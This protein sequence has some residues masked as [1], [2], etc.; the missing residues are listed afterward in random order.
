VCVDDEKAEVIAAGV[1][2]SFYLAGAE[3]VR[4]NLMEGIVVAVSAENSFFCAYIVTNPETTVVHKLVSS[5]PFQR[6]RCLY[7]VNSPDR[8]MA[9]FLYKVGQPNLVRMLNSAESNNADQV[10]VF[11]GKLLSATSP[12]YHAHLDIPPSRTY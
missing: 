5:D 7:P 3:I 4:E 8:P 1:R 12:E 11:A 9:E 10:R 2:V 6:M